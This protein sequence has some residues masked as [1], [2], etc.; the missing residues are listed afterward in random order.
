[1]YIYV[2][3]VMSGSVCAIFFITS[4]NNYIMIIIVMYC[5]KNGN[6]K[7]LDNKKFIE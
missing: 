1:M 7:L 6:K 3:N 5:G 2:L 4:Q